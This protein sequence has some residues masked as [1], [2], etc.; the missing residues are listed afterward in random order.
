MALDQAWVGNPKLG[1]GLVAGY[2]PSRAARRPQY[3]WFFAGD[4][5]LSIQ[6]LLSAGEYF[7]K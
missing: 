6:A 2:G 3:A 7:W 4:A 5:M 1:C